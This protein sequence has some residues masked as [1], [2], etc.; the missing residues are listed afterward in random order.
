MA[1]QEYYKKLFFIGALWNWSATLPLFIA[2]K[3]FMTMIGQ[4]IPNSP[5]FLQMFLGIAFIF[6]IGY[7][8]VSQDLSRNHDIVRL[9]IAGKL[10][11]L[12]AVSWACLAGQIHFV[13]IGA[14]IGD[15]IFAVL[16]MEFLS[17]VKQQGL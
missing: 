17:T 11:V 12:V 16:Y 10:F 5:I 15:L 14:G 9:G 13:W 4:T 2:Y 7:Y 6:G 8:W 3:P 1:K